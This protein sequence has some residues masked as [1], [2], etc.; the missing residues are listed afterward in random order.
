MSQATLYIYPR[1]QTIVQRNWWE[2]E[3]Q[4]V[5]ILAPILE[6]QGKHDQGVLHVPFFRFRTGLG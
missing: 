3:M 6:S 1:G 2:I 5:W 4:W